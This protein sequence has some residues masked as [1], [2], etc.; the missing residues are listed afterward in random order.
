M[1]AQLFVCDLIETQHGPRTIKAPAAFV[2]VA[3]KKVHSTVDHDALMT[4]TVVEGSTAELLAVD[5]DPRCARLTPPYSDLA[6]LQANIDTLRVSDVP[7][8]TILYLAGKRYSTRAHGSNSTLR[9]LV[10]TLR[11]RM[12]LSRE[13][14]GRG[15]PNLLPLI[16]DDLDT[17]RAGLSPASRTAILDFMQEHDI[18]Q[19][20]FDGN[21]GLRVVHNA[22]IQ[23]IDY[24]IDVAAGRLEVS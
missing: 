15:N 3:E 16:R 4:I 5:A 19:R 13:V 2:H 12:E 6:E 7:Q 17:T 1:P 10:R 11:K 21:D 24:P 22:I 9:S 8:S 20:I 18:A 23:N 14:V